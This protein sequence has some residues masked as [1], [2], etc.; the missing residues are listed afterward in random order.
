[1]YGAG[2]LREF[3]WDAHLDRLETDAQAERDAVAEAE[4]SALA[5]GD[6][7]APGEGEVERLAAPRIVDDEPSFLKPRWDEVDP[8]E[9]G[10]RAMPPSRGVGIEPMPYDCGFASAAS[11]SRSVSSSL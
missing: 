5:G 9:H 3:D 11:S 10:Y 8:A 1:M 2:P 6:E 7:W 4:R